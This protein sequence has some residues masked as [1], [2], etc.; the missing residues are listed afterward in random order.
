ME[1]AS[2]EGQGPHRAVEPVVM[3]VDKNLYTLS[4]SVITTIYQ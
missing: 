3:M 4:L 2:E 1:E